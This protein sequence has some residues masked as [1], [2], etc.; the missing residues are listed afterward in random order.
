MRDQPFQFE[1]TFGFCIWNNC[2][3]FVGHVK[4]G[5]ASV[6]DRLELDVSGGRVTGTIKAIEMDRKLI[7][8]TMSGIEIGDGLHDF[9]DPSIDAALSDPVDSGDASVEWTGVSFPVILSE[10]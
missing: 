8:E 4:N 1:S 6:G 2:I 9:S 7:D 10:S 3:V 5:V